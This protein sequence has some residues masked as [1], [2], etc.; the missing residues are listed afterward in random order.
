MRAKLSLLI[1]FVALIL[2]CG[3]CA[4]SQESE[5]R[6][7]REVHVPGNWIVEY[8]G[9]TD[10][11]RYSDSSIHLDWDEATKRLLIDGHPYPVKEEMSARDIELNALM[12]R[13]QRAFHDQIALKFPNGLDSETVSQISRDDLDAAVA[14]AAAVLDAHPFVDSIGATSHES[15]VRIRLAVRL[16]G[17]SPVMGVIFNPMEVGA[18]DPRPEYT[19]ESACRVAD[20]LANLRKGDN[21][22]VYM[23]SGGGATILGGRSAQEYLDGVRSR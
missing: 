19:L 15:P 3:S 12:R 1:P 14:H 10:T 18:G 6:F 2:L 4:S 5:C 8:H 11:L 22:E 16:S 17:R 21:T 20:H 9:L 23:L 7:P 13:A